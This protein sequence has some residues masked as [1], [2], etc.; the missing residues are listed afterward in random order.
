MTSKTHRATFGP[1]E[2]RHVGFMIGSKGITIN[3]IKNKSG[4]WVQIRKPDAEHEKHWFE[5]VGDCEQLVEAGRLLKEI[6]D[7]AFARENGTSTHAPRHLSRVP[8]KAAPA[9]PSVWDS[10]KM[11]RTVRETKQVEAPAIQMT[12]EEMDICEE[13]FQQNAAMCENEPLLAR[14]GGITD[15]EAMEMDN[16][17]DAEECFHQNGDEINESAMRYMNACLPEEYDVQ[18]PSMQQHEPSFQPGFYQ[19]PIGWLDQASGN[20]YQLPAYHLMVAD[21]GSFHPVHNQYQ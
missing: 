21:D 4:A 17:I 5:I 2:A 14:L 11:P 8:R 16:F 18:H 13:G 3:M 6:R 10:A 20:W 15:V 12:Q 19:V 9:R 7:E 1:V